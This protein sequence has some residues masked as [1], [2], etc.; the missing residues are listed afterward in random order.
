[1]NFEFFFLMCLFFFFCYLLTKV[2]LV[3]IATRSDF[4]NVCVYISRKR[5]CYLCFYISSSFLF[6]FVS[7]LFFFFVTL[8]YI[9]ITL[10]RGIDSCL[11]GTR[12]L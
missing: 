8:M 11:E 3:H 2:Q 4:S 12:C 9:T 10:A 6:A 1:M 5:E 7:F